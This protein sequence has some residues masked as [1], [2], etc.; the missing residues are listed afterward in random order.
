M[1]TR[2]AFRQLVALCFCALISLGSSQ[3]ANASQTLASPSDQST[4]SATQAFSW[5]PNSAVSAYALTIGSSLGASDVHDSGALA[6]DTDSY[7]VSG[8][9]AH[10][11]LFVR[12]WSKSLHGLWSY[13]AITLLNGTAALTPSISSPTPNTKLG[14]STATFQ[15]QDNG[16]TVTRYW[17]YIGKTR[18]GR[19]YLSRSMNSATSH[20]INNLPTDGSGVWVRLW[21]YTNAWRYND[22]YY[23][24]AGEG[25]GIQLTPAL[26]SR[27]PRTARC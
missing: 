26:T 20:T 15:W 16:T 27:R 21:Y 19:D 8:L 25:A 23:T 24:A 1:V 5:H 11:T 12:L 22:H 3:W 4:Y 17:L 14:G 10:A 2:A 7:S 13:S 9:G 18:G 6:A